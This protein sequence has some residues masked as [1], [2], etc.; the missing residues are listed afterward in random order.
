[1]CTPERVCVCVCGHVSLSPQ[2]PSTPQLNKHKLKYKGQTSCHRLKK[3]KGME[4]NG[5]CCLMCA[6][7]VSAQQ[8]PPGP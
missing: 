5:G 6:S 3:K 8:Q 1:M 4:S 7:P 2:Y